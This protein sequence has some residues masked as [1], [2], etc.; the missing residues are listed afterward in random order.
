MGAG[1][2]ADGRGMSTRSDAT[3]TSRK[4]EEALIVVFICRR[5]RR[6][7]YP[8]RKG[9]NQDSAEVDGDLRPE[10]QPCRKMFPAPI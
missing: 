5:R 9:D 6:L 3:S 10:M 2:D 1:D 7:L 4:E 8:E